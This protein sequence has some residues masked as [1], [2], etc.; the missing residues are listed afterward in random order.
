MSDKEVN[1]VIAAYFPSDKFSQ[2]TI[3]LVR[4][5]CNNVERITR[6]R[7]SSKAFDLANT[8]AQRPK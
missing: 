5:A 1:E 2:K 8:L 7:A 6:Q 3:D 4:I